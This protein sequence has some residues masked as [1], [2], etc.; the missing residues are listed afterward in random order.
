MRTIVPI[1][2]R[3]SPGRNCR[4]PC[5]ATA[6]SIVAA[7]LT[8]RSQEPAADFDARMQEHKITNDKF[9]MTNF[10]CLGPIHGNLAASTKSFLL[11]FLCFLLFKFSD[12]SRLSFRSLTSFWSLFQPVPFPPHNLNPNPNLNP[13]FF[14]PPFLPPFSPPKNPHKPQQ[15]LQ[16]ATICRPLQPIALNRPKNYQP[17]TRLPNFVP[18]A[19]KFR[20]TQ[21]P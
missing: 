10:Q 9:S 11:S 18:P 6:A 4:R 17:S 21:I 12:L 14:D 7:F 2:R 15:L 8:P 19:S 16:F 20:H 13:P 5:R 3:R 1:A